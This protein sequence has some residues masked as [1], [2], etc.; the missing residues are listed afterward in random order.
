MEALM[1]VILIC[2]F[3]GLATLASAQETP[4]SLP[5]SQPVS[6]PS[7]VPLDEA[8]NALYP[9][10]E[11]NS[12]PLSNFPYVESPHLTPPPLQSPNP[13]Q[14]KPGG[15]GA[16]SI[17][18]GLGHFYMGEFKQGSAYFG[19]VIGFGVAARILV[20][21][22]YQ[23]LAASSAA[24]NLWF[25]NIFDAYRD[26]RVKINDA[27]YTYPITR[28][29]LA[30]LVSAPF[31][32]SVLRKP[33]V[34]AGV[35]TALIG[36][37]GISLL[38]EQFLPSAHVTAASLRP[39]PL[40]GS[41]LSAVINGEDA[42][43]IAGQSAIFAATFA[44]V[45]VGEESLFRGCLQSGFT[46]KLGPTGGWIAASLLFGSAHIP[47]FIEIDAEGN[48]TGFNEAAYFAVPY[49]TLVGAGLGRIYMADGYKLETNIAAHFWYDFLLSVGSVF[50][51]ADEE[52]AM[53]QFSF[54]L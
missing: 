8:A 49:I 20:A 17:L 41:K 14:K 6:S 36:G 46:Q 30:K 18:P 37:L 45:G 12:N 33:W 53:L 1:R 32:P 44:T 43:A 26:A 2:L 39:T 7:N 34:W 28:E 52:P 27:G 9:S 40:L 13:Y 22:D 42:G 23:G 25:Y 35:P 10:S 38:A 21:N 29:P 54:P 4:S 47:N 19:G 50:S 11:P 31:R 48:I 24:Q 15:V 51:L 5:S 16:L 3:G